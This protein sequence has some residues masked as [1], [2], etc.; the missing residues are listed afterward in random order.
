MLRRFQ[1]E[2][3]Q[4]VLEMGCFARQVCLYMAEHTVHPHHDLQKAKS[5]L[6]KDA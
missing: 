3:N 1:A 2:D 4:S 6:A 5:L